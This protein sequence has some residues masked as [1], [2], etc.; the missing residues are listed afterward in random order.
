ALLLF[1]GWPKPAPVSETVPVAAAVV[2]TESVDLSSE[3]FD[4]PSEPVEETPA[5]AVDLMVAVTE[6]NAADRLVS[7]ASAAADIPPA[8]TVA[9]QHETAQASVI[10]DDV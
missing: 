8:N 3:S 10:A 9:N 1:A 6:T 5:D 4:S 7:P 2:S